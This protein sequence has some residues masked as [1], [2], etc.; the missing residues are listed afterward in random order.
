MRAAKIGLFHSFVSRPKRSTAS[1][2]RIDNE[3]RSAPSKRVGDRQRHRPEQAAFHV[4]QRKDRKIGRDDDRSRKEHR[5]LHLVNGL[6]NQF[7]YRSLAAP[8]V[9]D[10][11]EDVLHDDHRAVHYHA[12]IERS[13]REEVRR[14]MTQIE[15]DRSKK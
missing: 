13:Q 8:V 15:A 9:I 10:V 5:P 11:T 2:G 6:A 14:H 7:H 3:N 12:E 1:T 4:L